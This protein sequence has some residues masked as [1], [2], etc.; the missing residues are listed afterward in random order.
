[1]LPKLP[2]SLCSA[3]SKQNIGKTI[4]VQDTYL[5]IKHLDMW[6]MVYP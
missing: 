3:V 2:I 1:M 4:K 6:S 5:N